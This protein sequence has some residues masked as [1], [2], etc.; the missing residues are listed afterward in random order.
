MARLT[1][2]LLAQKAF[3]ANANQPMLDLS[4]GGQ[5]GWAPNLK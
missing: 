2:A 3:G 5:H 1:E 4:Y